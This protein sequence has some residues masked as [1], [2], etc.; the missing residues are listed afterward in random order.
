MLRRIDFLAEN[1]LGTGNRQQCHLIAQ[2]FLGTLGS[3]TGL[4]LG[5]DR[6]IEA[7]S[8][9]RLAAAAARRLAGE[10]VQRIVGSAGFF[11][12]DF[13]LTPATLVPRPDTETLVEAVLAAFPPGETF[14][15]ADLGVGSGAILVTLLAERPAA[16]G[17][18]TDLSVEALATARA[19]AAAL[20]VADRAHFV[21]A[22]YAR[23][24]APGR[25]DAIVSNPPYIAGAE[26]ETLDEEVRRHDPRLALDGGTDGLDAYRALVPEAVAALRPDGLLALEIGWRQ[27]AEVAALIGTNGFERIATL[28]DLAGR[29]RVI[30][31][32]RGPRR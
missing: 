18:A 30:T 5:G 22:S 16:I 8:A 10:P 32:R 14:L 15:F 20:G 17:V 21:R 23:A 31:A 26:I 1:L 7:A 6:P 9:D 24:L 29:D 27:A 2:G 25:F 12:R 11:G 19:N 4:T 13:A 3:H 28:P